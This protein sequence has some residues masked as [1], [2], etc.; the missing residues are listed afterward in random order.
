[1]YA[2]LHAFFS[3][4]RVRG[5]QTCW[6]TVRRGFSVCCSERL[7]PHHVNTSPSLCPTSV[8]LSIWS[9]SLVPSLNLFSRTELRESTGLSLPPLRGQTSGGWFLRFCVFFFFLFAL[10]WVALVSLIEI[11]ENWQIQQ[12]TIY[13]CVCWVVIFYAFYLSAARVFEVKHISTWVIV[14]FFSLFNY[15]F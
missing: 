1:M 11:E 13:E 15:Y 14:A 2:R 7:I 4:H 6:L 9:I 10:F 8:S 5:R 12:A 3:V